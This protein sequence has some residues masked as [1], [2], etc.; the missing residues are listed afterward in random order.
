MRQF[1]T[2][3]ET[4]QLLYSTAYNAEAWVAVLDEVAAGTLHPDAVD[5]RDGRT[6]MHGAARAPCPVSVM[7]RLLELGA[8]P[9]ILGED[10]NPPMF[11][12]FTYE[13]CNNP[14]LG[15]PEFVDKIKLLPPADLAVLDRRCGQSCLH[16]LALAIRSRGVRYDNAYLMD[17]LLWVLDQPE[18]PVEASLRSSKWPR[19][20]ALSEL[21]GTR[22]P[23][24]AIR[25]AMEARK[26]WA[27]RWSL[28]RAAWT[29]AVLGAAGL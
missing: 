24:R 20:T 22:E 18:C 12:V 16:L 28:L 11:T 1:L 8:S 17:A 13:L 23:E 5:A 27:A 2:A 26:A 15:R 6:L 21:R 4:R 9:S 7:A 29:G 10:G 3:S 25:A 14:W 19:D